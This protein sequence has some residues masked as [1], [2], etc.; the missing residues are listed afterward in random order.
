MLINIYITSFYYYMVS[1]IILITP[2]KHFKI[3]AEIYYY[4][5]VFIYIIVLSS[6]VDGWPEILTPTAVKCG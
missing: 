6:G 3:Y 2:T 1:N 4:C 5:V